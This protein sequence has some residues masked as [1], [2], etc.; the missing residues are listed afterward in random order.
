MPLCGSQCLRVKLM[1]WSVLGYQTPHGDQYKKYKNN[2]VDLGPNLKGVKLGLA[3]PTYMKNVN[4]IEDLTDQA[5]KKI[6]GIE[7]GAGIMKAANKALKSYSNSI[8]L[9]IGFCFDRCNDNSFGS[10]I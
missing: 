7:P 6:T 2:I 5:D 9:E 3:V 8:R 10:S 4:R 1:Q